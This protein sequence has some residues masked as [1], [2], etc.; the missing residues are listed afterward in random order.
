MAEV[1]RITLSYREKPV[2]GEV[3][4]EPTIKDLAG[5]VLD[6]S[7]LEGARHLVLLIHGYNN[8][9]QDAQKAYEGFHARQRDLDADARYGDG[10]TF[11][12]V[13]WP[14]DA[15]WGFAS[16]LFYM[17]SIKHAIQTAERFSGYLAKHLRNAVRIDIVAHSMGCRLGLELLRSLGNQPVAPL[18]ER[19]VFMAG[20]APTFMLEQRSPPRR[21][22]PSYDQWLR[23]GAR[24]LYSGSDMVLA[25]AF[26]AGQSLAPG[27]EGFLPTALG[28]AKW[29]DS[30][31]PPNL[32]Q[33]ENPKAGHGDYWGWNTKPKPLRCA[34]N[35][36][37]EVR[38]YLQFPSA[39][40]RTMDERSP[41]ENSILDARPNPTMRE[42]AGRDIPAY[43]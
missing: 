21:L 16:F 42:I 17:G 29:T 30:T 7:V 1:Q 34:I 8:D 19:I 37:R 43:A 13:Y 25:L 38:S 31:V 32:D 27:A 40:S 36:A 4:A 12:E 18:I 20:A 22:R 11:V 39:G 6:D 35:A 23:D 26:P 9:A 33:Q 3:S 2:G 10:R 15:A 41:V 28:H 5:N 14:G 24:S